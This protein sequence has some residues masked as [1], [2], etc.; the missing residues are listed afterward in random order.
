MSRNNNNTRKFRENQ[1]L[2]KLM[3]EYQDRSVKTIQKWRQA[4]QAAENPENPRWFLLQDIIKDIKIDAHYG[5]VLGLRKSATINTRFYVIDKKTKEKLEEQYDVLNRK[6]FYDFLSVA[7]DSIAYKYSVFEFFN[8]NY[9]L[10]K[11]NLLPR[12]NIDIVKKRFYFEIA[13]DNYATYTDFW[14]VLEIIDNSDFG[15]I[16]DV[17]PNLIWKKNLLQSSAEFSE[18]FGMPLITAITNGRADVPKINQSLKNLG[19]AA[20]GVFDEGTKIEIHDLANAGNPFAVYYQPAEFHDR[21]ISK[22]FLSSS[23]ITDEGANRAQTEV[24][25]ENLDSKIALDD[26]RMLTFIINDYLFPI[27]QGLGHNFN[28]ETMRFQFDETENLT[29]SQ[30]WAITRDALAYYDL[31]EQEV[32]E[33]FNLPIIGKKQLTYDFPAGGGEFSANFQ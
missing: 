5:S 10:I 29:L 31:D 17:I 11:F 1:L 28:N 33:T 9:E 14:N 22:R 21:Q 26:K 7:L 6:W 8:D 2:I 30:Q 12:R 13:G 25:E 15:L 27:L 18:K 3:Q 23:T 32:K 20:T 24:H 4:I 16:N 19:E